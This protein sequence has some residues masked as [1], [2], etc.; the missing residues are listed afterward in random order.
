MHMD[1][2]VVAKVFEPLHGK[3]AAEMQRLGVPGVGLGVLFEG[4]AHTAGFGVTSIENPLPV[5]GDTLFQ[6][7]STTKTYTGTAVMRLIES[8]HTAAHMPP[9]ELD[10]PLRNYL[11]ELQ[12]ANADAAANVTMRHLLTH[13]SGWVGDYFEDFGPGPDAVAR[14]IERMRD[15][16]QLTAPGELWSYN[17]ANFWLAGRVIEVITGKSWE[18]A[19]KGL[20]LDPLGLRRSF[21]FAD[22]VITH[23][24]AVGHHVRGRRP[25]VARRWSFPRR[26]PS[27]SIISSAKDQLRYARFH[28]GDGTASS[29]ERLLSPQTMILMQSPLVPRDLA[30]GMMGLTWMLDEIDGVRIVRHGG[31]TNGQRSAF[32]MVPSCGFAMT[33]L[34]N[35]DCG[36]TLHRNV[37]RWAL[38]EFLGLA[39]IEPARANPS[40]E[41]L[42]EYVGRYETPACTLNIALPDI[43]LTLRDSVLL[44]SFTARGGYPTKESP[45]PAPPPAPLAFIGP[46]RVTG[47]DNDA[48]D[49][50]GEFLRDVHGRITWFR[51]GSR[52]RARVG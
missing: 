35:A 45:Q 26:R 7:G 1:E 47:L 28:M 34:T 29:G 5:D 33:V 17:N 43:E 6:I 42:A 37:V 32:L 24:F 52:I 22:D 12:L 10:A 15:L 13:T 41:R 14:Y 36:A 11:P 30:G 16:P 50:Y 20:V 8:G 40:P 2:K 21:F 39:A 38:R 46:D 9:L 18:S 25:A 31:S 51:W 3:I 44:I 4:Q 48:E 27:G 49:L 23:R 19:L